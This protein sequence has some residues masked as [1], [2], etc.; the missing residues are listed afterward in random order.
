MRANAALHR[1]AFVT[2][3]VTAAAG[4]GGP[5]PSAALTSSSSPAPSGSGG[6]A[7]T[8]PASPASPMPVT[9]APSAAP[10]TDTVELGNLASGAALTA[11]GRYLWTVSAGFGA[12]DV[13]IVDTTTRQVCQVIPVA[14]AS[15]G[16][17]LDTPHG[18][19]YVAG[20]LYSRW[21]PT[22]K[23]LPAAAGNSIL[24]YR[25]TDTCGEAVLDRVIPVPPPADAPVV[26]QFPP[27]SPGST[28]PGTTNAWP[29]QVAVTPDGT[30]L[31][32]ALNLA[33]R[34]AVVDLGHGDAVTYVQTGDGGYPYGAAITPDGK[35]GLV[36]N[37]ASGEMTLIDLAAG[38]ALGEIAVGPPL[39]HPEGVI[40]DAAGLRAYVTLTSSDLVAVVDLAARKVERT[41]SVGRPAGL[42]TQPLAATLDTTGT[43][44]FVAESGAAELAVIRVPAPDATTPAA[45]DWQ[46][47]GRIPTGQTPKAV[48]STRTAS[49]A[50]EHLIWVSARGVN[51][52]P[53]STGP[54]PTDPD[55]PI[56][57]AFNPIA[58][59]TDV[60]DGST[61]YLPSLVRG[62][63]GFL[64]LPSDAALATLTRAADA[65]K[66]PSAVAVAPPD[67]PLRADG[68]IEHVFF[69]VRE[70][71]SYDQLLGDLGRGNGDPSLSVFP[72]KVTPN[73]HALVTRF[74][75]LDNVL[76]NSEA[77]IEGHFWTA[78]GA[79]PDYVDRNWV[80][81]Y[82]GRLRPNDFGT[83]AV[84]WPGNGF[85]FNQAQRQG[86][87][88]FNYGEGF[89]GGDP[90]IPDRNRSD[91]D[92]A[93]VAAVAA[94]SDLGPGMTGNGCYPS[95]LSIGQAADKAEIFDS[96]LIDGPLA[97]A[98]PGSHSHVDCFAARFKAQLAAGTVPALSYLS[99][100]SD[101][102]RGTQPGFR[103][104]NAMV[105]DSDRAVGE[106]V[107]L[108][109]HSSIW[110]SSAIFVVE[111]DS[112]DGADHVDAHRIPV[113]VISPYAKQG[114]VISAKYDLLSFVR[115]VEL[116]IGMDPLS[117]ND[118]L[119][120]PLYDAFTSA[121]D[122]AAPV[123]V[124]EPSLDMLEYNK[125][126]S[127]WAQA[128]E[129]LNLAAT[130]EVSQVALDAILWHSV[131]GATS[132]PPAPGPNAEST[133]ASPDEDDDGGAEGDAGPAGGGEGD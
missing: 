61:T 92:E 113:M 103:V 77:S 71:R 29:Q 10:V 85:L 106:I 122:N 6:P 26:Q 60:F 35:T 75:L 91:A 14:G 45:D 20:L 63:A 5:A 51:V 104:P 78:A 43:R 84:S 111:D 107:D 11:D 125:P 100:T 130:D 118:A 3:L 55:D 40:V 79:V 80:Q 89:D 54:N 49:G 24:V 72:A 115:S 119:A 70:N 50:A 102:T 76:A 86:I 83:Y 17:A 53:N 108:V 81:Q 56:F 18:L 93:R 28:A 9:P 39:S 46:V 30:R 27:S 12:N 110:S 109:S 4:C 47:I 128:S 105:A 22:E 42:G 32:V 95:D 127:P 96:S 21:R 57:W 88:Y 44:L 114:A 62:L 7:A 52:G 37:E 16:I 74:P 19:A 69:I 67:T 25:W 1:L 87:T 23:S 68:P 94:N 126:G 15:G 97:G 133:S 120:T 13:R 123:D 65:S 59:T 112:Q 8:A 124:I 36:T 48:L 132:A 101:H 31:L 64:D 129:E 41:I 131:H 34:A 90:S 58:P 2:A 98:K 66:D 116:I 99:L 121:P 82:A 117:I 33:D 38:K 73:L